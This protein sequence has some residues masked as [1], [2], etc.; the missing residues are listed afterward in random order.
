MTSRSV[1]SRAL[2]V[3]LLAVVAL[4]VGCGDDSG[5]DSG[6]DSGGVDG[7]T[8]A[9]GG[10]DVDGGMMDGGFA[11]AET[12]IDITGTV[13]V[14]GALDRMPDAGIM[15]W[16]GGA[17]DGAVVT[18]GGRVIATNVYLKTLTGEIISMTAT[19]EIGEYSLA[20][21][22]D[23]LTFLHVDPVEGYAG[24]IRAEATRDMDYA[25]FDVVLPEEAGLDSVMT[26]VGI[27]RN[28]ARGL[29]ACGFNPVNDMAGGDG[30]ELGAGITHDPA[31]NI[32]DM[33]AILGNRLVP[34]CEM[35]GSNPPG[36][37]PGATCTMNERSKQIFFPNVQQTLAP[38]MPLDPASG[39][40]ALRFPVAE[41]L[42]APN[43]MTVV[44]I[45]CM[46]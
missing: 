25:A 41:W 42:T 6:V 46:P 29:I 21:P 19:D 30:A 35:D 44:N 22:S 18:P 27:T 37:L 36:A 8:P 43:C 10:M 24:Q 14:E 15:L 31:F 3:A 45:D 5:T 40:C 16:D 34:L 1:F 33:G 20:A 2:G 38:V 28:A 23:M 17:P 7:G 11:D 32:T 12:N 39:T 13:F 4:A 9:D 26:S